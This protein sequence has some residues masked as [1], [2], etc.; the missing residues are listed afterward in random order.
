[1]SFEHNI[2]VPV[3]LWLVLACLLSLDSQNI[4]HLESEFFFC[5]IFDLVRRHRGSDVDG[6]N[7]PAGSDSP[8]QILPGGFDVC[9]PVAVL[10][11]LRP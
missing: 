1:M 2:S 5:P 6:L 3:K 7:A 8:R 4:E 10:V 9:E 11:I